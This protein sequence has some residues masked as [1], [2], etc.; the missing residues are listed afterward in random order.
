M[1]KVSD[2]HRRARRDQIADAALRTF[3]AKG[4]QSTSM[5]DIIATSGLSAGAIYGHFSSK[6]EIMYAVAARILG[7]RTAAVDELADAAELPTPGEMLSAMLRGLDHDLSDTQLLLQ[8]WGASASDPEMHAVML[9]VV[10]RLVDTYRAYLVR[11]SIRSK[12]MDEASA[13]AFADRL[14]PTMLGLAQGYIVQRAL[15]PDFDGEQYLAVAG[16]LL[17]R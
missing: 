3:A 11:W 6:Q 14:V 2:A 5:A 7:N 4:F 15:F 8:V 9:D 17:P 1:P 10:G 13:A 12:D 16:E